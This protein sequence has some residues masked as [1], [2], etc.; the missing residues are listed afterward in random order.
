MDKASPEI[1]GTVK[2]TKAPVKIVGKNFAGED[3]TLLMTGANASDN[4]WIG[5]DGNTEGT[6]THGGNTYI[7]AGKNGQI[8]AVLSHEGASYEML[9]RG[10][11]NQVLWEGSWKSGDITVLGAN[12]YRIF[13]VEFLE[14]GC[15]IIMMKKE[16]FLRGIGGYASNNGIIVY[17]FRGAYAGEK[18]SFLE[19]RNLSISTGNTNELTVSRIIGLI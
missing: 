17:G 16:G 6:K 18:F 19:A 10:N 9:H 1:S 8:R 3:T 12:N 4:L 14:Q 11:V 15:P 7:S 13:H 2:I 5:I